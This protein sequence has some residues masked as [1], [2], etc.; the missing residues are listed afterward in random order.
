M[1]SGN[2]VGE[3]LFQP[4]ETVHGQP[5]PGRGMIDP[6]AVA[7]QPPLE[8][9]GV[10]ADIVEQ[11]GQSAPLPCAETRGKRPGQ[12]SHAVQMRRKRLPR[13]LGLPLPDG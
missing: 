12:C 1:A 11:P 4:F 3:E 6:L 8:G 5:G 10:F 2:A 13:L 9:L 7:G